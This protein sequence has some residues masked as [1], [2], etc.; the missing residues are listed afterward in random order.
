[1]DNG[2][3]VFVPIYVYILFSYCWYILGII[4]RSNIL[5]FFDLECSTRRGNVPTRA[6][7]PPPVSSASSFRSSKAS[8]STSFK[9]SGPSYDAYS[10]SPY[11]AYKSPVGSAPPASSSTFDN[12]V[13]NLQLI[14]YIN[15]VI[16]E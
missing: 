16:A 4:N 15:A 11:D 14:F 12:M 13:S 9:P 3:T 2:R 6:P 5:G 10:S 7:L 1:M 8:H